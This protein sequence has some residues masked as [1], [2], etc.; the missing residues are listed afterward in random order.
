MSKTN[1]AI[2]FPA[3]T[4]LA[5]SASAGT[6][7]QSPRRPETASYQN[8]NKDDVAVTARIRKALMDDKTLSTAAHNVTIITQAG[9]VTLRGSVKSEDEKTAVAAK[10]R[11]IAGATMVHDLTTVAPPKTH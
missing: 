6:P 10:A 11:D 1:F 7:V 3:W 4:M 2:I 8:T 9:M 5:L